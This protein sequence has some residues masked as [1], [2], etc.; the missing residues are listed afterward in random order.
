[1]VGAV[2]GN[3]TTAASSPSSA[4]P[5]S[6]EKT[7]DTSGIAAATSEPNM[8]SS[9]NSAQRQADDLRLHVLGLLADLPAPA[10]YSTC[11]PA[12]V[13]GATAVLSLSR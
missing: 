9:S 13:A 12:L 6:T 8:A 4:S 2:V 3:V 5:A 7:A 10:P 11:R 1:M